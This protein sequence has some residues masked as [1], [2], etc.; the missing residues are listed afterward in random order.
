MYVYTKI[1]IS[2]KFFGLHYPFSTFLDW[3]PGPFFLFFT[4][5]DDQPN[6]HHSGVTEPRVRIKIP[7]LGSTS[8]H[9]GSLSLLGSQA[10]CQQA[11]IWTWKLHLVLS[12]FYGFL[13]TCIHYIEHSECCS[14]DPPGLLGHLVRHA[15]TQLTDIDASSCF[16]RSIQYH[17]PTVSPLSSLLSCQ[18]LYNMGHI[19]I[20]IFLT[21]FAQML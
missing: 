19:L 20:L 13:A 12:F 3:Q 1:P 9:F 8:L 10:F 21:I 4:A 6:P 17:V 15:Q 11:I 14:V 7:D 18:N 2:Y 16:A 5:G